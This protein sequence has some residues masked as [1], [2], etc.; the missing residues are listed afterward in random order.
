M[1]IIEKYKSKAF[2]VIHSIYPD[3]PHIQSQASLVLL[4]NFYFEQ[5]TDHT[6]NMK[7][8]DLYLD[9]RHWW[10]GKFKKGKLRCH[11]C[12]KGPLEAGERD[13]KLAYVNNKNP[14]LATIDHKIPVSEGCDPND[15]DNWLPACKKCNVEKANRDYRDFMKSKI[16]LGFKFKEEDTEWNVDYKLDSSWGCVDKKNN[17]KAFTAEQIVD[18]K[19]SEK[20]ELKKRYKAFPHL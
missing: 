7:K 9:L 8:L 16:K 5:D 1:I 18:L 6:D 2:R 14:L 19:Q 3:T 4:N 10:L 15:T 12:N 20:L 11:Y 13:I 17:F